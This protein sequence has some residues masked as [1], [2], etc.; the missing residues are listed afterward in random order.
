MNA[1]T[2]VRHGFLTLVLTCS[3]FCPSL[4]AQW[5]L[6]IKWGKVEKADLELQSLPAYP[7]ATGVILT[8]FGRQSL[9]EEYSGELR[10]RFTH[11]RQVKIFD[12]K[13][14][15]YELVNIYHEHG[16]EFL[17]K[18]RVV[19]H[20]PNGKSR[21]LRKQEIIREKLNDYWSVT[22][23]V[24]PEKLDGCIIDYQYETVTKEILRFK[25]WNF[26]T[27]LPVR[28]SEVWLNSYSSFQYGTI[29]GAVED[30]AFSDDL[31]EFISVDSKHLVDRMSS[32]FVMENV[33]PL[34]Q[35]DYISNLED[36]RFKLIF[37]LKDIINM[38]EENQSFFQDW[39]E[40]AEF[41]RKDSLFG[42]QYLDST[43]Y[44]LL[45]ESASAFTNNASSDREI[46][47]A[48]YQ[49]LSER[50]N[51]NG[52]WSY[53]PSQPI[54]E[55]LKKA[56][57]NSA[58]LNMTLLTLLRASGIV[59][60]PCLLSTRDNG[61]LQKGLANSD[62]FNHLVVRI[63]L[64][65]EVQLLDL[66]DPMRPPGLIRKEAYNYNSWVI[67][68]DSCF[69]EAL[70]V[71]SSKQTYLV[72]LDLSNPEEW[73]AHTECKFENQI[74]L[75]ARQQNADRDAEY[76]WDLLSLNFPR[77]KVHKFDI[78]E[79]PDQ[80]SLKAKF[81]ASIFDATD[82]QGESWNISPFLFSPFPNNPF[83]EEQRPYPVD[84][85]FPMIHNYLLVVDIPEGFEILS[86]P[87]DL[88]MVTPN[89]EAS[90]LLSVSPGDQELRIRSKLEIKNSKFRSSQYPSLRQFFL[91]LAKKQEEKIVLGKLGHKD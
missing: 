8:D 40:E 43:Q 35:R 55:T 69:F 21:Y 89:K 54:S 74:A 73:S 58:D 19:I 88:N 72:N 11:H 67:Q 26:Q 22:G 45:E 34:T 61:I 20:F 80:L 31:S 62:Q 44:A 79:Q 86:Y 1:L 23:F 10:Y 78:Q 77:S 41:L 90:Y 46:I 42:Q 16:V 53:Y 9:I 64:E 12:T 3:V 48:L 63:P 13:N 39:G 82:I 4:L 32:K 49:Q 24:L 14:F 7:E 71:P 6:P 68:K 60:Q 75:E 17:R 91:Q 47:D 50:L 59:A 81:E 2:V 66:G 76:W 87:K 33:A 37:F 70:K 25:D 29:F 28:H 52:E 65:E 5:K 30:I 51:W 56:Q 36:Y 27:S 38:G 85:H 57:G 18:V 83:E 84:F 15:D